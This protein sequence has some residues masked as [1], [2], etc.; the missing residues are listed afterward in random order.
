MQEYKTSNNW[1]WLLLTDLWAVWT[2]LILET[3]QWDLFPNT[4]PFLITIEKIVS[5]VVTQ[6][7]IVKCTNKSWDNLTIVRSAWTCPPDDTSTT[8]W[9]TAFD[10]DDWDRVSLYITAE[11]IQD[12]YLWLSEKVNIN[13][14][15]MTW[16]LKF[17]EWWTIASWSAIELWNATW[18]TVRITWTTTITNLWTSQQWTLINVIFDWILTLTHNATA[19]ILP[20]SANITTAAWDTAVFESKWSWNWK[21]MSYQRA[22]WLAVDP[23]VDIGWLTEDTVGDMDNDY[24][25]KTDWSNKKILINKYRTTD[26]EAKNWTVENKFINPKQAKLYYWA[27]NEINT[28][29]ATSSWSTTYTTSQTVLSA[30]FACMTISWN[31]WNSPSSILVW[32]QLSFNNSTWT[33]KVSQTFTKDN[34]SWYS[35]LSVM[36]PVWIYV[37]WIIEGNSD[38]NASVVLH[39]QWNT[40]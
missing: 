6:R 4:Y 14:S 5:D 20:T 40:F 19:L 11:L 30:W 16:L 12:I 24:I 1:V 29:S 36:V 35:S 10:F 3:G 31:T 18:N 17:T 32:I 9:T 22:D 13:G 37:R 7:E 23:S 39:V 8:Q 27:S 2:T 25:V 21:C 34:S 38:D 33:T 15:S 26:L 28:H